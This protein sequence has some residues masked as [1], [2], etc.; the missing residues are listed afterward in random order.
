[1]HLAPLNPTLAWKR[2]RQGRGTRSSIPF[3]KDCLGA[4]RPLGEV[5]IAWRDAKAE[6]LAYLKSR[7]I[8]WLSAG[9]T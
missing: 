3:R 7:E 2:L 6:A 1:M 5:L 8:L 9:D 4:E